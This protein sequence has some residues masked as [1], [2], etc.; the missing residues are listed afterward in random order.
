MNPNITNMKNFKYAFFVVIMAAAAI[1][2][3][4][5]SSIAGEWDGAFETPGGAR[6]FK[7]VLNVEGDKITGTAKRSSGDV[8]VQGKVNGKDFTFSYTISYNG[9]AITMSFSGKFEADAM[10]GVVSFGGQAEETFSAK[11]A[12]AAEKPKSN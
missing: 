5:Q 6:P 2:I 12:K 7:V 3:S 1:S 11:R 4:A 9:N 8:P 10:T